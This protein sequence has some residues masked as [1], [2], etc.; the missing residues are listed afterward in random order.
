LLTGT[1]EQRN[2]RTILLAS[3]HTIFYKVTVT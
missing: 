1:A 3:K 2:P